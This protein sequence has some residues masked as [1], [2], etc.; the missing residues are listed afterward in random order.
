MT[1]CAI[2]VI[3]TCLGGIRCFF[4]T[5]SSLVLM[6]MVTE[7]FGCGTSF[8]LTIGC[9]RCPTELQRHQYY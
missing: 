9:H 8:V 5:N 1:G 7:V 6:V 4:F 2:K 3:A